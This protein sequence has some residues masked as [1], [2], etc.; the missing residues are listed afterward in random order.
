MT[1]E[2]E[3]ELLSMRKQAEQ[4]AQNIDRISRDLFAEQQ[5]L[6]QTVKEYSEK[7]MELFKQKLQAHGMT[8]CTYEHCAAI[9]PENETK[10]IFAHGIEG[11]RGREYS[12]DRY[13]PFSNLH[14][15]C[16]SC[17][18][19]MQNRHGRHGHR[20]NLSGRQSHFY[21]FRVE[22]REDGYYAYEFGTWIRIDDEDC[23]LEPLNKPVEELAEQWNLP[24]RIELRSEW[25]NHDKKLI[26]HETKTKN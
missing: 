3:R 23:L 14:R 20:D 10:L 25:P 6:W 16:P 21:A 8:W 2:Q 7:R 19:K 4:R 5:S 24:P 1:Q 12:G 17:H 18:E 22:K 13:Q 15:V 26:I 9:V 11:H